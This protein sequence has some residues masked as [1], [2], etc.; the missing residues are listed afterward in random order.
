MQN[1]AIRYFTLDGATVA[2]CK[3]NMHTILT[4]DTALIQKTTKMP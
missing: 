1:T 4:T 3:P 2:V